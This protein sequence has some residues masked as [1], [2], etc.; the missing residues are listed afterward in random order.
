M[1]L[2][3]LELFQRHNVVVYALPAHTSG[4]TQPLDVV[5]FGAFKRALNNVMNEAASTDNLD[6]WDVFLLSAL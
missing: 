1:S 4:K 2:A 5:L 6:N 3:V